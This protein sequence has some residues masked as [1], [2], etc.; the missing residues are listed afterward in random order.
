MLLDEGNRSDTVSVLRYAQ[1][2]CCEVCSHYNGF[3]LP[4]TETDTNT[5]TDTETNKLTQNPI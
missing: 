2:G 4:D 1:L 5:Q 3:T